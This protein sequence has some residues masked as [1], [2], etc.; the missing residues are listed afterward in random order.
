MHEAM[1]RVWNKISILGCEATGLRTRFVGSRPSSVGWEE[2]TPNA[3]VP[4]RIGGWAPH[5]R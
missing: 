5:A 2:R 3:D 1:T 4:S